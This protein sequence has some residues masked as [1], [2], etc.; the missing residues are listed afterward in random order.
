MDN[1]EYR[2]KCSRRGL[3]LQCHWIKEFNQEETFKWLEDI[4]NHYLSFFETNLKYYVFA[5]EIG[6]ETKGDHIQAYLE[7]HNEVDIR[8]ARNKLGFLHTYSTDPEK[9]PVTPNFS[10]P[11]KKGDLHIARSLLYP[12]KET[13]EIVHNFPDKELQKAYKLVKK[14]DPDWL[15]RHNFQYTIPTDEEVKEIERLKLNDAVEHMIKMKRDGKSNFEAIEFGYSAFPSIIRDY[16]KW[17]SGLNRAFPVKEIPKYPIEDYNVPPEIQTWFDS[18][19][20][21]TLIL[22]GKTNMGKTY[23]VQALTQDYL[24]ISAR[25]GLKEYISQKYIIFDDFHGFEDA[26]REEIIALLDSEQNR[27]LNVKHGSVK[28]LAGTRRIIVTN[29][30]W[31]IMCKH[32]KDPAVQRRVKIHFILDNYELYKKKSFES[33]EVNEVSKIESLAE[34]NGQ[35]DSMIVRSRSRSPPCYDENDPRCHKS[36]EKTCKFKNNS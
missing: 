13:R 6:D 11:I 26:S 20:P 24:F 14:M 17:E 35:N 25:E 22:H 31:N 8:N 28:L 12:F 4:K 5:H 32:S 19:D 10:D 16:S 21:R 29:I 9:N 2:L 18:N 27:I 36:C 23:F 30:H 34:I 15:T 1:K 3:T 33:S 7:F